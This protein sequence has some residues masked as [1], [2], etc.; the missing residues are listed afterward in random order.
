MNTAMIIMISI[1]LLA[2]GMAVL[3]RAFW[4]G[5]ILFTLGIIGFMAAI[6]A[7]GDFST[8]IVYGIASGVDAFIAQ[9]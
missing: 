1:A 4:S 3:R 8:T 5:Q 7:F 2:I 9:F 6:P